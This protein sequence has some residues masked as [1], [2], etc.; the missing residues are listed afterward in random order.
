MII[1]K[2][3]IDADGFMYEIGWLKNEVTGNPIGIRSARKL[4]QSK[5]NTIMEGSGCDTYQMYITGEGNFRKEVAT[6]LEYKGKRGGKPP[7]FEHLREIL[8]KDYNA[9]EVTGK[10][11]DDEVA[12][13]QT[14][15]TVL[16]SRDKDLN[17]VPGW[18]FSWAVGKQLEKPKWYITP[19]EGMRFFYMQ[20]QTGDKSVDNIPG[21]KGVG[22]IKAY[23]AMDEAGATTELEMYA[24]ALAGYEK[25]YGLE[26]F[27]YTSW[28]GK[29]LTGTATTMLIENARL[30][31]MQRTADE[32]LW[33][34]PEEDNICVS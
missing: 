19:E 8:L 26:E 9:F 17:M 21:L 16:C 23:K 25:Q 22:P 7:I 10:E 33:L 5:I 15:Y 28:D 24:V 11:A 18:H 32:E 13:Q 12:I 1:T 3:N 30:L 20:L 29:E 6:I 2:A 27:T 14:E 4:I 31:W 34:P